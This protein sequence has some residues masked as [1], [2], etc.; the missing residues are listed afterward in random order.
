MT[1][2]RATEMAAALTADTVPGGLWRTVSWNLEL[3]S[4]AAMVGTFP[5]II[6][7]API[8]VRP[9]AFDRFARFALCLANFS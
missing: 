9:S 6:E 7:T 3:K 1:A 8:N 2:W 4:G 5:E